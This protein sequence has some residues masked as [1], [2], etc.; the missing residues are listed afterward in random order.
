MFSNL[1]SLE[2][3]EQKSYL[4][5]GAYL[6]TIKSLISSDSLDRKPRIPYIEYTA[7]T[8]TGETCRIRLNG[9]KDGDG[10]SETAKEVRGRIF[11]QFIT[12]CGIKN[13]DDWVKSAKE[14]I[15]KSLY[16]ALNTREYWTNDSDGK[17]VV[18][19]A[20]EYKTSSPSDKPLTYN[21]SY[22]KVLSPQQLR[23][24]NEALKLH[25]QSED[26]SNDDL[27]F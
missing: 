12:N 15:G 6:V 26:V 10:T 25:G 23:E 16:I 8:K 14:A 19:K 22:N 20:V 13:F 7:E 4:K 27:P 2:L 5:E 17:P 11:K 18:R 1:N 9:Y 3:K 21:P 24:F